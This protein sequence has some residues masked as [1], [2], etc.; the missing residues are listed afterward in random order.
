M[1]E[2]DLDGEL[3]RVRGWRARRAVDRLDELRALRGLARHLSQA[4]LARALGVSQPA[5]SKRLRE[6]SSVPAVRPGFSGAS[7]YEIAQRYAAGLLSREQTL[8]E[9]SRWTYKPGDPGDGVDWLSYRPGEFEE[10]LGK[11]LDHGLVDDAMYDVL[12]VSSSRG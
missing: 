6:A 4:E 9:L 1:A 11:A 3:Q 2:Q 8:E 12:A 10:Q 5:V 7:A